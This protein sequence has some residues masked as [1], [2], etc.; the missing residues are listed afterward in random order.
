MDTK[1]S[2]GTFKKDFKTGEVR[3][4]GGVELSSLD[5][6]GIEQLAQVVAGRQAQIQGRALG[7]GLNQQSFSLLSGN[8][9]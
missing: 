4:T 9:G 1:L 7:T 2:S 3:R 8:F 5:E 6:A